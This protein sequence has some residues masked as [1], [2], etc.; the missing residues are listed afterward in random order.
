MKSLFGLV[1]YKA[2]NSFNLNINNWDTSNV[3]NM[4]LMFYATGYYAK[5]VNIDISGFNT[6]KV[7]EIRN[8]FNITCKSS[9]S[10]KIII[11]RTNS[12]G[13]NNT[14]TRLYGIDASTYSSSSESISSRYFTLV[15]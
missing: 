15:E 9:T 12:N 8:M 1:G 13:I 2:S 7:E 10:C 6:S 4:S 11:P 3:T 5:N 14:T